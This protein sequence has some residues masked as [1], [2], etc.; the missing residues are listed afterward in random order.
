MRMLRWICGHTRRDRIRND[1][2][3]ERLG[4]TSV[5]EK[6]VQHRLRWFGHIQR[7]PPE[8]PIRNGVIRQTDNE[9]RAEDDQT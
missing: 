3:R 1:D 7:R 8:A 6:L 9:K 2:I 4:V 5:E